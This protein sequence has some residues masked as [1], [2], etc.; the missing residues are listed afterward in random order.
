MIPSRLEISVKNRIDGKE[1][2]ATGIRMY[3]LNVQYPRREVR[4]L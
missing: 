4:G 1:I 3:A 2:N